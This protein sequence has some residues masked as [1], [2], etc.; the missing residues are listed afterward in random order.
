M[1]LALLALRI[2]VYESGMFEQVKAS[3]AS[4]GNF[5]SC[6]RTRDARHATSA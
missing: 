3:S 6:S 5:F 4:R 2:G 1:G